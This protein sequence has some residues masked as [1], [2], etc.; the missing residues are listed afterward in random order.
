MTL[1]G[2]NNQGENIA[3]NG[4]VKE[5]YFAYCKLLI[6]FNKCFI[7]LQRP[8][9]ILVKWA[10]ENEKE[11]RLPGNKKLINHEYTLAYNNPT[12]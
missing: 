11:P 8:F 1:D 7:N 2:V 5:A 10:S 4:G 6:L 12:E 3:D 9:S